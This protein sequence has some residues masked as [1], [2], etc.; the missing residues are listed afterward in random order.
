MDTETYKARGEYR[1]AGQI[2]ALHGLPCYYGCHFGMRSTR[3]EA[4]FQYEQG[5]Q[6]IEAWYRRTAQ[7]G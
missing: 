2:D 7:E 4:M 5:W 6:E 3:S 1:L